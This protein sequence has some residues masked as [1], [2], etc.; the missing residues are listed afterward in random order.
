MTFAEH[1]KL[2]KGRSAVRCI[3]GLGFIR[4]GRRERTDRDVIPVRISE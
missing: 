3:A 1:S 4:L 2:G